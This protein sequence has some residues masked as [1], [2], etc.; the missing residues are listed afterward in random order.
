M[1]LLVIFFKA[2]D[3]VNSTTKY[4]PAIM[5]DRREDVSSTTYPFKY[6]YID[7]QID[8]KKVYRVVF[9]LDYHPA[10][11]SIREMIRKAHS[12]MVKDPYLKEIFPKP[13]MR[14]LP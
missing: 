4:I 14:C 10:L 8:K 7:K 1:I 9:P 6:N 5:F 2:E 12:A 3:V 13:P 11:P